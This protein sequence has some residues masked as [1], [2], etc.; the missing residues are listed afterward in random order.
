MMVD[1]NG[2]FAISISLILLYMAV[3]AGIGATFSMGATIF[4]DYKDDG[5][6]FNG[7]VEVWDYMGNVIG[8]TIAGAGIGLATV[9]GAGVGAAVLGGTSLTV[10]G[11]GMSFSAAFSIGVSTSAITGGLGYLF[12]TSI[13]SNE[14][15]FKDLALEASL[16]AFYGSI[17]FIVGMAGGA[18][19]FRPGR[20][21]VVRL[22]GRTTIEGILTG[23]LKGI[24]PL[25]Q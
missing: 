18:T 22:I 19:G 14:F 15:S 3:S 21:T 4:E 16:G 25:L 11:V 10:M 8:G 12:K 7:S 6:I 17:G 1:P 23:P 9:L 20:Q 13:G 24:I 5:Q 2:N